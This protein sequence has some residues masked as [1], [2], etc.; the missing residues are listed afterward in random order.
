MGKCQVNEVAKQFVTFDQ[1]ISREQ[2]LR[3]I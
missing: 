3:R 1:S 2:A